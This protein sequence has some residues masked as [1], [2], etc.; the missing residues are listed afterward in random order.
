MKELNS[1]ERIGE[2]DK[3]VRVKSQYNYPLKGDF[4]SSPVFLP[5][6]LKKK[7]RSSNCF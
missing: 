7:A 6:G 3:W 1:A 2:L 4:N 5:W